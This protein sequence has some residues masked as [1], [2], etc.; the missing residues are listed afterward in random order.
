[1]CQS[2][3][4][5]IYVAK[6]ESSVLGIGR[7]HVT[8]LTSQGLDCMKNLKFSKWEYPGAWNMLLS[9][10]F[11][12]MGKIA[13][14]WQRCKVASFCDS[15]EVY[16]WRHR[17]VTWYDLKMKKLIMSGMYGA[18]GMP[19]FSSPLHTR[20]PSNCKKSVWGLGHHQPPR[21]RPARVKYEL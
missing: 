15:A 17:S 11:I 6:W 3:D 12:I 5:R 18:S 10:S 2:S 16:L 8:D 21:P 13:C 4:Y 7:G 19:C 9:P 1:M 20:L 14:H